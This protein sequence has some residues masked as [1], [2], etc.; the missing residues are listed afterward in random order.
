MIFGNAFIHFFLGVS[1]YISILKFNSFKQALCPAQRK[2]ERIKI[3]WKN[4][5]KQIDSFKFLNEAKKGLL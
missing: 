2:R 1:K 3:I 4:N 5:Y